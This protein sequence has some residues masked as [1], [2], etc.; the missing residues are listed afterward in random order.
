MSHK[1]FRTAEASP[2]GAEPQ[3]IPKQLTKNKEVAPNTATDTHE[4]FFKHSKELPTCSP[5]F[6]DGH[7]VTHVDRRI[8]DDEGLD[9]E[10]PKFQRL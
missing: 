3:R 9:I 4:F 5:L 1:G 7:L 10:F 6:A 8:D 2:S